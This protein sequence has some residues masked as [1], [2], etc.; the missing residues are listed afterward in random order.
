M[1]REQE[2]LH[3]LFRIVDLWML[4]DGGITVAIERSDE[5]T[6]DRR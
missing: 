1:I 3:R 6:D 4:V 2:H 5:E